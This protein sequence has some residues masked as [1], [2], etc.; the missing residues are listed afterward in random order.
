VKDGT[1]TVEV[2]VGACS[3]RAVTSPLRP[4]ALAEVEIGGANSAAWALIGGMD[5]ARRDSEA[6]AAGATLSGVTAKEKLM[7]EVLDLDEARA[8]RAQIVV[9]DEPEAEPEMIGVPEAWKTFE[10]GTP[11]PNWVALLHES[12]RGR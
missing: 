12:R 6:G 4:W 3:E 7:R 8:A 1:R 5:L 11:Q 2:V 10:D 9:L